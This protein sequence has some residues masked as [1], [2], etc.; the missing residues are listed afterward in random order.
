MTYRLPAQLAPKACALPNTLLP[1]DQQ[2]EVGLFN[3]FSVA[4]LLLAN[5][6]RPPMTFDRRAFY[7]I[8]LIKGRSRIEFA[9]Q[10][11]DVADRALWFASSRV[12]YR[13]LPHGQ[14][15][16]G[17]FCIF[18]DEFLLPAKGRSVVD[19]LPVFQP[20]TYPLF[21]VMEAEY[22]A[23]GAVFEK[24]MREIASNYA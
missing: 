11:A 21:P 8:S 18:T 24:M 6:D 10:V 13:W 14:D 20:G 23:I 12:P 3:V 9:D 22:A 15:Q 4:D 7:K 2:R 16:A 1:T 5:R 17:Y 19:E